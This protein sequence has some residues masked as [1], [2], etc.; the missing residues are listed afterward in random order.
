MKT[1]KE[2]YR[3]KNLAPYWIAARRVTP[4][5]AVDRYLMEQD[6]NP[7][8]KMALFRVD[9]WVKYS[10]NSTW[11]VELSVLVIFDRD[12]GEYNSLRVSPQCF[13][14]KSALDYLKPAEVKK[15][16]TDKKRVKRQG[17]MYFIPQRTWNLKELENTSHEIYY[18]SEQR[19][20]GY[21]P[22]NPYTSR[23]WSD[24]LTHDIVKLNGHAVIID[25][26]HHK[27]LR[28]TAP[29]KVRQQI[30]VFGSNHADAD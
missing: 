23:T 15:A 16:E 6:Y 4:S 25:H 7:R 17:D 14:I 19:N 20:G 18:Q 8:T 26:P 27:P 22:V 3:E 13:S 29:H 11:Y 28:L 30:T 9:D 24:Y 10:R 12:S 5:A 2:Q 21:Y 1:R